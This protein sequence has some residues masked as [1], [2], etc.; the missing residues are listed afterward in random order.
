MCV[1]FL[2]ARAGLTPTRDA[3]SDAEERVP[4]ASRIANCGTPSRRGCGT[5]QPA[6]S[7]L[8][9]F[10]AALFDHLVSARK[11]GRGDSQAESVGGFEIDSQLIF[12]RRLHRKVSG[13]L[14]LEDTINVS[15]C[16]P[17]L[18]NR[19]GAVGEQASAS[20]EVA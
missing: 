12:D 7:A 19:I 5:L 17:I 11:Q 10:T 14:A 6:A 1:R 4:Q 15:C 2:G 13:L 16:S 3:R 9:S 18:V 20:G 8:C